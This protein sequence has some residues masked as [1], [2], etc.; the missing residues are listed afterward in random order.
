MSSSFGLATRIARH[1]ARETATFS[2]LRENRNSVFRGTSSPLED[3]IEKKTT[4][5]SCPWNLSTV[6]TGTRG[7][8][9][10][11]ALTECT[12]AAKIE[13][14]QRGGRRG[15]VHACGERGCRRP[16]AR[17]AGAFAGRKAGVAPLQ[18]ASRPAATASG[19]KRRGDRPTPALRR[20]WL[21]VRRHVPAPREA[22]ARGGGGPP[23]RCAPRSETR[24]RP[25]HLAASA[26]CAGD[27]RHAAAGGG[28]VEGQR[29]AA[30]V[31]PQQSDSDGPRHARRRCA[32]AGGVGTPSSGR[33]PNPRR[34]KAA[35]S[36][37]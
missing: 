20:R 12:A 36:R 3:A 29:P 27:Q 22:T 30:G 21:L 37:S 31:V 13:R 2:R 14:H 25:P 4:G 23:I 24:S 18:R 32:V 11:G 34:T 17:P 28:A 15:R 19:R 10:A 8:V 1:F 33:C 6:P 26:A 9:R 5:A 35:W 7:A 16:A